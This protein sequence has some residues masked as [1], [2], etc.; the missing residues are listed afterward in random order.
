MFMQAYE[1][2]VC[3]YLY[4]VQSAERDT[5]GNL[6]SFTDLDPDWICPVCGVRLDLFRP[7]DS[8]RIPDT[9]IS[10]KIK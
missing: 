8:D 2:T 6:I 3:G 7:V 1:C 5:E 4:D 10:D 9:P